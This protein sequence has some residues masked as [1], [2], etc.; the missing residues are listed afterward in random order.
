MEGA[1][2]SVLALCG[3]NTCDSFPM[4]EVLMCKALSQPGYEDVTCVQYSFHAMYMCT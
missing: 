3:D 2:A 4:G 1:I